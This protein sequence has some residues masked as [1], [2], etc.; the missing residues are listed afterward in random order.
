MVKTKKRAAARSNATNSGFNLLVLVLL[1]S[2]F[3]FT[4]M[5][6]LKTQKLVYRSEAGTNFSAQMALCKGLFYTRLG[7]PAGNVRISVGSSQPGGY[8]FY[9]N[10]Q[11]KTNCYYNIQDVNRSYGDLFCS[12]KIIKTTTGAKCQSSLG[13]FYDTLYVPATSCIVQNSGTRG[14]CYYHKIK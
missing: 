14:K 10:I 7:K 8:R 5:N 4:L 11:Y 2:I 12:A 9:G 3:A 13:S 6:Y 1:L